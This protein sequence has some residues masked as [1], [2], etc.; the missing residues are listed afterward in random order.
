MTGQDLRFWLEDLW[1]DLTHFGQADVLSLAFR[2]GVL[3]VVLALLWGLAQGL[4][5]TAAR[6][7]APIGRV[8]TAPARSLQRRS[9]ARKQRKE[10]RKQ[11]EAWE[12]EQREKEARDRMQQE[13][14]ETKRLEELEEI[15]KALVI[16]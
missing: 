4:T 11:Q 7:L 12:R 5:K 10:Y 6:V 16:D 2:L 13:A 15:K 9:R 14:Q 8:L 1:F 3:A